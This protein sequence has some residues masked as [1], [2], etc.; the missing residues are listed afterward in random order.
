M[1]FQIFLCWDGPNGHHHPFGMSVDAIRP[2]KGH[3]KKNLRI[4]CFFMNSINRDN[5]KKRRDKN[6]GQSIWNRRSFQRYLGVYN[7]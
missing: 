1:P 5:D 4:V 3:V 7:E 6:D 2:S